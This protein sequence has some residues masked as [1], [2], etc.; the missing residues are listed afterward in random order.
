MVT[1]HWI[2]LVFVCD[3]ITFFVDLICY[4][5]IFK[6]KNRGVFIQWYTNLRLKRFSYIILCERELWIKIGIMLK[7]YKIIRVFLGKFYAFP[8]KFTRFFFF[9]IREPK[10]RR[11]FSNLLTVSEAIRISLH[12]VDDSQRNEWFH[13]AQILVKTKVILNQ[14]LFHPNSTSLTIQSIFM[15]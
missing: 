1:N 3:V 12:C 15:V 2:L 13:V 8:S 6:W 14:T 10:C 5:L 4:H 9:P 11:S 7:W